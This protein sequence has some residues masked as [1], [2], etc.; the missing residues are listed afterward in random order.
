MLAM[1]VLYGF[2]RG[3]NHEA[4]SALPSSIE[5]AHVQDVLR[6][7]VSDAKSTLHIPTRCDTPLRYALGEVDPRFGVEKDV[8][9]K[10]LLKAERVWEDEIG[11]DVL[12]YDEQSDFHINFVFDE[13][14]RKTFESKKLEKKLDNVEALQKGISKEYDAL[15]ATHER[16]KSRY[17][18]DVRTYDR[19]VSEYE[20]QVAEYTA[21]GGVTEAV[22]QKLEKQRKEANAMVDDI[23]NQRRALNTTVQ[24][25]NDLVKKE[26]SV[27]ASYN[28]EV[29]TYESKNGGVQEFDQGVYTGKEI[30]IYQFS[31]M[32]DLVLVLAHELGHA[33]GMNH[34]D[35]PHS[36]M[37]Y[38][39]AEQNVNHIVPSV[40]DKQALQNRCL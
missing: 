5:T 37:Y 9:Q 34:V 39:M 15:V 12:V 14:Q 24:Q 23:E 40:E 32:N 7:V 2:L 38:L 10:E 36:V 17:E 13:R 11:K 4:F 6:E 21:S 25:I 31:E 30:N 35:N 18:S 3:H 28:K 16:K 19:L 20:R 27:V 1:V 8:L 22:Y 33:L 26:K 29:V